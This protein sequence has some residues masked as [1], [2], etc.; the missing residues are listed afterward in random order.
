MNNLKTLRKQNNLTQSQLAKIL[1]CTAQ[2]YQRYEKEER[3]ADYE[4]LCKLA[5]YF[6][7]SVDYL[8]GRTELNTPPLQWT[9]EEKAL[10]VVTEY[11]E[12]LSPDE[13]ELLDL[14]RAVRSEKGEKVAQAIKTL[15]KTYLDKK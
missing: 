6:N 13:T 8:L 5:D 15:L 2:A 12:K 11:R 3:E 14:Y 1:D 7:T 4:T 9:D 10:G